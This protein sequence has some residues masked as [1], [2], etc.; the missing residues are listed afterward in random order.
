LADLQV[1]LQSGQIQHPVL[2]EPVMLQFQ[3]PVCIF[4]IFP[5]LLDLASAKPLLFVP[6][7]MYIQPV[8]RPMQ[9]VSLT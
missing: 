8:V 3:T 9:T 7:V 4:S 1:L 5:L 2:A 6:T